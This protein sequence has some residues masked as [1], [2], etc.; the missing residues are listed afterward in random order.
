MDD[1]IMVDSATVVDQLGREYA[2]VAHVAYHDDEPS[3]GP[4]WGGRIEGL[5]LDVAHR[6]LAEPGRRVLRIADDRE[7]EIVPV[8][9]KET[10]GGAE[11]D[12]RGV[13]DPP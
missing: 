13:N 8:V 6:L 2:V 3:S 12:F 9:V 7:G 10:H 1:W 5:S 11:L 4:S